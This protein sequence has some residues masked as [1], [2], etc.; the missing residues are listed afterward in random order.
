MIIIVI[1][2]VLM[3]LLLPRLAL[4]RARAVHTSCVSNERLIGAALQSYANDNKGVFPTSLDQLLVGNPAPMGKMPACPSNGV[5]YLAGYQVNNAAGY[6]TV[7]CTGVHN[8]QGID[9]KAGYP[10]YYSTGQMDLNGK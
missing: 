8:L 2:S 7:V 6:Y 4:S 9:V 5:S 1:A 10:Q 3:A